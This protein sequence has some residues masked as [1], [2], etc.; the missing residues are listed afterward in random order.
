MKRSETGCP[1]KI[2]NPGMLI[3]PGA[4]GRFSW[5]KKAIK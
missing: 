3:P 5:K 1:Q 2:K 4:A